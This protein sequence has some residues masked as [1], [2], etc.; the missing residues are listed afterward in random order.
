MS[1]LL[2]EKWN[3]LA[4][5]KNNQSINESNYGYGGHEGGSMASGQSGRGSDM[6]LPEPKDSRIVNWHDFKDAVLKGD[7]DEASDFLSDIGCEDPQDQEAFF[8]D[9]ME[10]PADELAK[11]WSYRLEQM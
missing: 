7:I 5:G 10:L 8:G 4:F 9:A 1:K 3:R 2:K 6:P 11:E